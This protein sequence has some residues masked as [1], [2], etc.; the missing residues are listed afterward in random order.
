MTKWCDSGIVVR[1]DRKRGNF[2][3]RHWQYIPPK[4]NC[5]PFMCFGGEIEVITENGQAI[6]INDLTVSRSFGNGCGKILQIDTQEVDATNNNLF[7]RNG[8]ILTKNHR[9]KIEYYSENK[10]K[11]FLI[12]VKH[13]WSFQEECG[14]IPIAKYNFTPLNKPEVKHVVYSVITE[15]HSFIEIKGMKER[16]NI[17]IETTLITDMAPNHLKMYKHLTPNAN[18]LDSK[19]DVF[20]ELKLLFFGDYESL[21]TDL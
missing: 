21:T 11:Y 20:R 14:K 19:K 7:V 3:Q 10:L 15:N 12:P 16:Q 5:L 17:S 8:L 6:A 9:V 18:V 2:M 4:H 13:L 1:L